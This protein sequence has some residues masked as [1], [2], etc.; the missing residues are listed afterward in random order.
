MNTLSIGTLVITHEEANQLLQ[1][2]D[3]AIKAGGL[4]VAAAALAWHDRLQTA[5]KQ[6]ATKSE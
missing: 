3:L 6:P 1:L 2:L 4:P 5:F